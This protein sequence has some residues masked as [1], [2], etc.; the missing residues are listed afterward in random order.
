[1]YTNEQRT[2]FFKQN[3]H[4]YMSL[5]YYLKPYNKHGLIRILMRPILWQIKFPHLAIHPFP[6]SFPYKSVSVLCD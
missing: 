5:D 4:Y 2:T 1:M 3:R 6:E